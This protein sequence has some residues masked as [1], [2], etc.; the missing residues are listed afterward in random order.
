MSV[1]IILS[2]I[3]LRISAAQDIS[4]SSTIIWSIDNVNRLGGND[5]TKLG[6][7]HVETFDN[8]NGVYFDG[9]DDGL[10]VD[11]NPLE[12]TTSFTVELIFKP[13]SS[14][15]GNIEQ[16]FIHIQ[17][18]ANEDRRILLELRLTDDHQWYLDIFINSELSSLAL[19]DDK[20]RHP[21]NKWYHVA[22]VYD[23][24]VMISYVN[25]KKQLSGTVDYLPISGAKTS[26]GTRMNLY[27]WFK[28]CIKELRVT[29]RAL[30]A[31]EFSE[32]IFL[33]K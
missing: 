14:Y 26:I 6:D 13:D 7:P 9:V 28:G 2:M 20:L 15:P 25:G 10:I 8:G 27:S 11:A 24:G 19:M 31:E 12:G 18:P 16:R 23:N 17:N 21:V 1:P 30:S 3:F 29:H 5:V 33:L 32:K 22:M 4:E